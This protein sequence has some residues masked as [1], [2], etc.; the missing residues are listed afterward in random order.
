MRILLRIGVAFVGVLAIAVIS[1]LTYRAYR[2]HENAEAA[3]IRSPPGV[4]EERYVAIGGIEQWV[5][6]RG[7][8]RAN[9]VLLMLD[10]GPGAATSAFNPSRWEKDFIVVGWD[11]PGAART[12]GR[13]GR[14]IDPALTI[15]Q[16]VAD[17]IGL[18]EYLRA[19]LHKSSIGLVGTSWGSVIGVHMI[20]ARPDLFY[21]Y[22]GTGQVVNLQRG[23]ALNYVHVLAKARAKGDR[24][25]IEELEQS[26][27]PPYSSDD[28]FHTQRKWASEYESGAL[29]ALAFIRGLLF[30]PDYS[31]VDTFNWIAGFLASQ[32][33]FFGR[34]MNGPAMSID[35]PTLGTDIA[36]PFFIFQGTE[37]DYTPFELARVYFDSIDAPQKLL[38]PVPGAGHFCSIT[39]PDELGALLRD[40]VRP[41]ATKP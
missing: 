7:Q 37:D 5:T 9:P 30:S 40:R 26:G 18:A 39:H 38:V 20:K 24:D 3:A 6:I 28:A 34:Q 4:A 22:V 32:D 31:L 17:G 25:A 27:P 33:H 35:L 11:Q 10:G 16:V 29:G 19:H 23:E 13:A 41:L 36:V 15:D 1:A 21:A 8:D 12:F 2:Q 14:V